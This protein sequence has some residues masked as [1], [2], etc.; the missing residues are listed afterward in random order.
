MSQFDLYTA[1]SVIVPKETPQA[2]IDKIT[3]QSPLY[4]PMLSK[5]CLGFQCA[6]FSKGC[7]SKVGLQDPEK[8]KVYFGHCGLLDYGSE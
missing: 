3:S 6:W 7:I 5:K 4:C 2:E 1:N 8:V